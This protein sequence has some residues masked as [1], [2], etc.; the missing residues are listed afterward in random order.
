[1]RVIEQENLSEVQGGFFWGFVVGSVIN[2]AVYAVNKHRKHEDMTL[3]GACISTASGALTGGVGG[4]CVKAAG[5]GVAANL[6]W[7]PG[8][9]AINAAGQGI[10]QDK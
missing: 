10:A 8:F 3:E 1:M 7:R 4:M 9:S 5:A 2:L 6:A